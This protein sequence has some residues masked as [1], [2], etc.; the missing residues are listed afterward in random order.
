MTCPRASCKAQSLL[1]IESE[2][3]A[4]ELLWLSCKRKRNT[5]KT[6][7]SR[8]LQPA[9]SGATYLGKQGKAVRHG[10]APLLTEPALYQAR[11]R[12]A[13]CR[14][15]GPGPRLQAA[16][17][18]GKPES[19]RRG[20]RAGAGLRES[21]AWAVGGRVEGSLGLIGRP[22][23][24]DRGARSGWQEPAS[25]LQSGGGDGRRRSSGRALGPQWLRLPALVGSPPLLNKPGWS[26]PSQTSPLWGGG[27]GGEPAG[28]RPRPEPCPGPGGGAGGRARSG[29]GGEC[30]R[31]Q[32]RSARGCRRRPRHCW[33]RGRERRPGRA[34]AQAAAERSGAERTRPMG[35]TLTCCVSPNASPKLGRRAGPAEPDYESETY[36]AAAGDAVAVAPTPAAA[37]EPSELDFG[38]GEGHHLQHISDREMPEGEGAACASRPRR[39]PGLHL[40]PGSRREVGGGRRLG[41]LTARSRLARAW[42][43]GGEGCVWLASPPLILPGA[44]AGRFLSHP[45]AQ[46]LFS[47]RPGTLQPPPLPLCNAGHCPV[48]LYQDFVCLYVSAPFPNKTPRTLTSA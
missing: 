41:F 47:S 29:R 28:V 32:P 5:G 13:T 15:S 1:F 10:E 36:A 21:R 20:L 7:A 30:G 43:P 38:A 44:A 42:A 26:P 27:G 6:G 23:P 31:A 17:D 3:R 14:S 9:K 33:G 48:G 46:F 34:E 35:N 22:S 4:P 45:Y 19:A 12:G 11:P 18:G 39:T 8:C 40:L 25:G 24:G 16:H 37:V 2:T